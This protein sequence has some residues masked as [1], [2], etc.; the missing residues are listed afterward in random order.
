LRVQRNRLLFR[1]GKIRRL[2][3]QFLHG[4]PEGLD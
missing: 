1:V 2:G 3:M 4:S